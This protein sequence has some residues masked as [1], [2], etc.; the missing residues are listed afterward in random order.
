[1]PGGREEKTHMKL[2]AT[3]HESTTLEAS[4]DE[5]VVSQLK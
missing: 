1:M 4:T 3:R 5:L 2:S